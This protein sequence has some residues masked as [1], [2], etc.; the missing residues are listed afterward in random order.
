MAETNGSK[1]VSFNFS[2]KDVELLKKLSDALDTSATEVVKHSLKILYVLYKEKQRI[3]GDFYFI[4]Q[5]TKNIS[6]LI[7]SMLEK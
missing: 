1:K 5:E 7:F 4:E 6:R 2:G 3:D